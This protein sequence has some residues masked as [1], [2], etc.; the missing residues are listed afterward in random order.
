MARPSFKID[1]VRLR[2]MR[3]ELNLTQLNVAKQAHSFLGKSAETADQTILSSYGRIERNGKTSKGMAA[4]LATIFGTT[5]EMLQGKDVLEVSTDFVGRI[6][7]QLRAQKKLGNNHVLLRAL[8]QHVETYAEPIDEDDYLREFATDIGVQI[9]VAQIGQNLSEIMRLAEL[10]GWTGL[11]LQ[12][13]GSV[14]GHWVLLSTVSGSRESEI[15]LGVDSVLFRIR[16]TFEKW[17]KWPESDVRITLSRSLPWFHV[18][19]ADPRIPARRVKFS[20]VRC[21]PEADGLKWVNPTWRDQFWL[22]EPMRTWAFSKTNLLTDIDG[23]NKPDDLRRLRLR[24][25]ERD[26]NGIFQRVAYSKGD[27]E[28]LPDSVFQAYKKSGNSHSI[29]MN[30]LAI[31]LARSL[32]PHLTTYPPECWKIRA[33]TGHIAILLDIPIRLLRTNN[34]LINCLGI[35]YSIDLVEEIS[36]GVYQVAPWRDSSVADVSSLL[37]KHVFEKHDDIEHKEILQFNAQSIDDGSQ[38]DPST[39]EVVK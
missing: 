2:S 38:F 17:M 36:L 3:E 29:V 23:K 27:L 12:Q 20:F 1:P 26:T 14:H 15:V 11:Q 32:A 5:V 8:K 13:P 30:W 16:D 10:T 25:Q 39:D 19:V 4:A 7:Q 24:V 37:N 9:E 28:C 34:E 21:R 31:G 18:E 35:K 22:E 6:E 33:G